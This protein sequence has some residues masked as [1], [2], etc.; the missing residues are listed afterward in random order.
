MDDKIFKVKGTYV[1]GEWHNN[2]NRYDII[3]PSNNKKLSDVPISDIK[4][5]QKAVEAAKA[6]TKSLAKNFTD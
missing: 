5:L 1:A 4:E 2:K 6:S 3:N